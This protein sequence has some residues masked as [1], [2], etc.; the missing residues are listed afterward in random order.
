MNDRLN[1]EDIKITREKRWSGFLFLVIFVIFTLGIVISGYFYYKSQAKELRE[2]TNDQ[3]IAIA[4]LKVTQLVNW[5]EDRMEDAVY[6]LNQPLFLPFVHQYLDNSGDPALTKKVFS[7]MKLFQENQ[8]YK[9]IILTDAQ[10]NEKI[11]VPPEEKFSHL[12]SRQYIAEVLRT[13]RIIFT[14]FHFDK[15]TPYIHLS[16]VIPLSEPFS[17]DAAPFG[18][19]VLEIDPY[20]FLYPFI[21][22]WPTLSKTAETLLVRR[23]GMR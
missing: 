16:L 15:K 14:D 11:S 21:Q 20:Q 22:T 19:L 12:F 4:D 2:A 1:Q 6:I 10:G 9:T 23:E 17:K 5:R 7:W 18:V 8:N 13:K 3:L